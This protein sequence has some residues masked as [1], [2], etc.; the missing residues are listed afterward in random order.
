MS[1]TPAGPG[2]DA[3]PE[4]IEADIAATRARLAGNVDALADKVDVKARAQDKVEDVKVAAQA[5]AE[6]GKE[7]VLAGS[8]Q[9]SDRYQG[10]PKPAQIA[11]AVAPVVLM[12]VL[13]IRKIRS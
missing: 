7:K 4:E 6:E 9:V 12:V 8:R 13:V 11:I 3:T 1:G 10:L 5:R 2:P